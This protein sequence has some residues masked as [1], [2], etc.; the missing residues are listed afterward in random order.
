VNIDASIAVGK[1]RYWLHLASSVNFPGKNLK[2]CL[3]VI[4]TD[5]INVWH[6]KDDHQYLSSPEFQALMSNLVMNVQDTNMP[7][8]H[9]AVMVGVPM[10]SALV[11][12]ISG[13][14]GLATAAPIVIPIVACF[15]LAKWVYD[16][17]ERSHAV[18]RILMT[19][20]I[21]LTLVMQ[22][23]F[24]LQ[25]DFQR[26]LSRRLIKHAVAV[27]SKSDAKRSLHRE[28]DKHVED[29]NVFSG[30][31]VTLDKVIELI[32]RNRVDSAEMF[33]HRDL[34]PACNLAED[35]EEWESPATSTST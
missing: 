5:I 6:F 14:A 22:N 32:G 15:V 7:D 3:E 17:Y 1:Q 16:V 31:D 23:I 35:D 4:H 11:S 27:Y 2:S 34:I 26:P 13:L 18:L 10:A 29:K 9:R 30:P 19:Y 8:P 12:I 25:N 20:I 21:D 24:W 28:I 33:K